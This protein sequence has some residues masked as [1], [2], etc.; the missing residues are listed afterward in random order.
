MEEQ[1]EQIWQYRVNGQDFVTPNERFAAERDPNAF[2][3][4]ESDD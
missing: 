2:L 1:R 4:Y 3:I